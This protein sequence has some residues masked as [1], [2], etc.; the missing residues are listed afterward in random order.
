M[1]CFDSLFYQILPCVPPIEPQ[2]QADHLCIIPSIHYSSPKGILLIPLITFVRFLKY[3]RVTEHV[4]YCV[5]LLSVS[6]LW[7][8]SM[9]FHMAMGYLFSFLI[10]SHCVNMLMF[11]CP[12][13]DIQWV[14]SIFGPIWPLLLWTTS[15][16]FSHEH[17]YKYFW[18][19]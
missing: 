4:L 16:R 3:Y 12:T 1:W 11:I 8:W 17:M 15:C 18:T 19:G 6:Y 13:G 9:L 7:D 10:V 14:V 5:W 2:T